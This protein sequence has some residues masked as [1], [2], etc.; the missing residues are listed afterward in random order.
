MAPTAATP[1]PRAAAKDTT[2]KDSTKTA[3][4]KPRA[5]KPPPTP[6]KVPTAAD[7]LPLE[8]SI[9]A[10][11]AGGTSA[12]I[13]LSRYGVLRRP[14]EVTVLRRKGRDKSNFA[15]Q[16]ELIPQ[17]YVVPLAD[18]RAAAPGFD[19]ARIVTVRWV[20]DGTRAGTVLLTDIGFSNIDPA[21]LIPERR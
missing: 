14:I 9:E 7:S 1:G 18:F 6:K 3:G 16:A 4:P 12:R 20:F 5:P 10:V 19:P 17:T 11:D 2:K 15:S 13:P 21:F 8:I